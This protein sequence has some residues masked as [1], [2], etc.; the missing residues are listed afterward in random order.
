M[1]SELSAIAPPP[2]VSWFCIR[3]ETEGLQPPAAD[4]GGNW[5]VV[6]TFFACRAE[7][8]AAINSIAKRAGEVYFIAKH[9]C[10]VDRAVAVRVTPNNTRW[11]V[12]E[13]V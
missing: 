9:A 7:G 2:H 1:H 5:L 6:P 12:R 4:S 10:G 11:I 3:L 8:C 13:A